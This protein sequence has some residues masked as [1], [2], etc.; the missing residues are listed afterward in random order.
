MAKKKELG[1]DLCTRVVNAHSGG[2]GYMAIL[3]ELDVPVS[4]VQSIIRMFNTVK[5]LDGRGRKRKV[6]SRVTRKICRDANNNSRIT[7]KALID[8]LN[9]AGETKGEAF[10]PKKTIPTVKHG[11]GHIML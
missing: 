8:T 11:G 5:N 2:K 9:Q 3:K 10:D 4:T 1:H 7:T 6:S